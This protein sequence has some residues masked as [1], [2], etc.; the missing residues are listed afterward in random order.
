VQRAG[1]GQECDDVYSG[2]RKLVTDRVIDNVCFGC[3]KLSNGAPCSILVSYGARV[4]NVSA[5]DHFD[6]GTVI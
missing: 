5:I 4:R 6:M 1:N 3:R 2:R